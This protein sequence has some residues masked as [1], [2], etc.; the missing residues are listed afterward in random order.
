MQLCVNH[1]LGVLNLDTVELPTQS[2]DGWSHPIPCTQVQ[3][4]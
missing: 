1:S 3:A 4:I 2:G